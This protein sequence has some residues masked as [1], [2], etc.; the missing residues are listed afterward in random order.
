MPTLPILRLGSTRPAVELLQLG[1]ARAGFA[2]GPIDG[3]FGATTRSALLAFQRANRLTPDGIAGPQTWTALEPMFLGYAVHI[4]RPGDTFVRIA[5]RYGSTLRAIEIANPGLN[6]LNLPIGG[7]VTV[8]YSF[9]IAPEGVAYTSVLVGY[10][11]RGLR[12][13]Y[14]FLT[15]ESAGRSVMMRPLWMLSIGSGSGRVFANGTHHGNEWITTALLLTWLEDYC[16]AYARSGAFDGAEASALFQS[17]KL[18]LMPMVDPDGADLVTGFLNQ[19]PFYDR[20]A[21]IGTDYPVI[22]FPEGWKANIQGTDL[23]LQYPTGWEEAK[24]IKYAQGY[25]T[26]APRDYVGPGPLTA[27]ESRAV[28]DITR[29]LSFD[30]TLSFHTQGQVI[31]WKGGEGTIPGARALGEKL[32]EASGYPLEATPPESA[33]AG[34]RDWFTRSFQRPG[35]TIEAGLGQNPLPISQLPEIRRACGPLLAAALLEAGNL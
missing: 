15:L 10:I 3:V 17:S 12:A 23:N 11:V 29:L 2:P 22:P 34:Y 24:A 31:F 27:P 19:G 8:P 26:P 30:L 28:Y 6:P 14:P 35:Y 21:A 1:L 32:S 5:E 16:A 9:P 25:T 4:I 18:W 20:A 13:R 7:S 33:N